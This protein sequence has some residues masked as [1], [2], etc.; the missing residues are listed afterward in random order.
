MKATLSPASSFAWYFLVGLCM[1]SIGF[2]AFQLLDRNNPSFWNDLRL[3]FKKPAPVSGTD[4]VRGSSTARNTVID[5]SDFQ[6][7]FCKQMHAELK[8]L[9][10][11]GQI[12]W[13]LRHQPLES[14]HPLAMKAAVASECAD[15]QGRFWEYSDALFE[16]QMSL[17]KEAEFTAL[18]RRLGLKE[19]DFGKCVNSDLTD[20][21][22]HRVAESVALEIDSTPTL[23]VNGKRING[24]VSYDQL[25][26]L[27][28]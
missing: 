26:K 18:A 25:T 23:F 20:F 8:R 9:S 22:R 14:I 7:P 19:T 6:C 15:R 11:S 24:F 21:V 5:Y 28:K 27:M 10:D 2:N 4:H 17:A 13:I 1:A 3:R 12:I 16:D